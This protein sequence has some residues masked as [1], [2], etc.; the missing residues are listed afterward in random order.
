MILIGIVTIILY[1]VLIAWT[2]HNLGTFEKSKK[3][4]Y[5]VL[6]ILLIYGFTFIIF[7]VSKNGI[8]Y[9]NIQIHNSVQTLLIVVFSGIN[10]IIIMPQIAK[11][12]EEMKENNQEKILVKRKIIL[13]LIILFLCFIF[14]SGYMKTT[15]EGILQVYYSMK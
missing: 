12:L 14:E 3:L 1:F 4:I 2:W 6:G 8:V 10:G 15:Q 13:L 9:E 5:L 11:I 7:Q